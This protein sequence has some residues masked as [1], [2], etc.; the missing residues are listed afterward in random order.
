MKKENIGIMDCY[1]K[2][3]M[4]FIRFCNLFMMAS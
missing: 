1:C 3:P 2:R 4:N